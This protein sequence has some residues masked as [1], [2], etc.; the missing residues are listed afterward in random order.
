MSNTELLQLCKLPDQ[1]AQLRIKSDVKNLILKDIHNLEKKKKIFQ[2]RIKDK[3]INYEIT[4]IGKDLYEYSNNNI[5]SF[6]N[7]F[8]LLFMIRS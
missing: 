4:K 7:R 2:E 8:Y 6:F 1:L 3:K 5:F